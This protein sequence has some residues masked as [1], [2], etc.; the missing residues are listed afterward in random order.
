[1][2]PHETNDNEA[3]EALLTAYAL[4]ETD[5]AQTAEVEALIERDAEA[6]AHVEE[7]RATAALLTSGLAA[8]TDE[9][10]PET[11]R[12][13][14][15][16]AAAGPAPA[17]RLRRLGPLAAMA[18][19][20]AAG[21]GLAGWLTQERPPAV[22]TAAAGSPAESDTRYLATLDDVTAGLDR[23]GRARQDRDGLSVAWSTEVNGKVPQRPGDV[24]S[25]SPVA[26]E[27]QSEAAVGVVLNSNAS[28]GPQTPGGTTGVFFGSAGGGE[29]PQGQ[30]DTAGGTVNY[31]ERTVEELAKAPD[32]SRRG[33]GGVALM[34][35]QEVKLLR[36]GDDG[37]AV[38]ADV[39]VVEAWRRTR[40]LEKKAAEQLRI[41]HGVRYG[42]PGTESYE[43]PGESTF[44]D[45]ANEPLSTFSIDVDTASY[46]NVRRFLN[47]GQLPPPAAV[48]IEEMVNYFTYSDPAPRGEHPIAATLETATCP[49]N[50]GSRL[51]RVGVK[52]KT[53]DEP[54]PAANL[55]FLIDVSGSMKD[56]DKLPLLRRAMSLLADQMR[57]GDRVAIVTYAS[58]SGVRLQSTDGSQ[59]DT[60][61]GCINGLSA[62]GSTNGGS[63]I[64]DA[65]RIAEEHFV[66][67]GINRVILATDG[68]FNVGVTDRGDLI[69]LIEEKAKSG[70]FLSVLGV[71]TGNLKDATLEQLANRGNGNYHYL[72]GLRE[73]RKVLVDDLMGTVVTVAKD[74]KIQIEFNPVTVGA[75]R[76]VGYENRVLA[77]RDFN[78]DGKDAGDLGAGHT[79]TALYEIVPAGT[80]PQPGVDPLRYQRSPP[81][82][83][84]EAGRSGELLTLKVRYKQPEGATSTK[85]EMSISDSGQRFD[86]ASEDLRF[87]SAV[88]SFG[89]LLRGSPAAAGTSYEAVLELAQSALGEDR[90]GHRAE[91]LD[92]VLKAKKLFGR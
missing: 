84:T 50:T 38:V 56:A 21:V 19:S 52:A 86:E 87:S 77:A 41:R 60:I 68:D 74:V 79:V 17:G 92:L 69:E 3:R 7:I 89:M 5:P 82:E 71:G 59:K 65:Y 76:L 40:E 55:V 16:A 31:F 90:G 33:K 26:A 25:A 58:N 2:N 36:A 83:A 8:E 10:L 37:A 13:E 4:G 64:I 80:S 81:Q 6:R 75:Y 32:G 23:P 12:A 49:W 62:G 45:P 51:V 18:A 91:M 78:D 44:R 57:E 72:D 85:F 88:A 73:A 43:H 1:M 53:F 67:G 29:A 14:L 42:L 66:Q 54:P 28:S 47:S 35:G 34:A 24:R 9:H 46:A 15:T 22:H 27:P 30:A 11:A 20:V 61:K 48:R 63:G 39:E 70:V